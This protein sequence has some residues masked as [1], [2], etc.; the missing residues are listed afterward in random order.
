MEIIEVS[1]EN[2]P[3]VNG[4]VELEESTF[5][6]CGGV[7]YWVLKALIRYGKV[8]ALLMEGEVVCVIEYM[9]KF[10]TPEVF[11]YGISTKES[12]RRRGLAKKLIKKSEGSLIELGIKKIILTVDPKNDIAI[13]LYKKEGYVITQFQKDEYGKGVDRYFMEKNLTG[14]IL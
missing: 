9:Q 3:L 11:L 5:G 12:W 14:D 6:E 13:E 10:E 1:V 8:Y 7:D 2:I 4:I